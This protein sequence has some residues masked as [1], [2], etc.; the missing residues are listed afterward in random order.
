VASVGG[1]G[2]IT[3]EIANFADPTEVH[4]LGDRLAGRLDRLDV[5]IHNA[6]AL[7]RTRSATAS[8]I[9]ATVAVHLLA[10][11]LL[12]ERLRPL[13]AAS[14]PSRV[15][16]MTSGGMYAQRFDLDDLVMTD[17]DYD[18]TVAY[19]RAKRAQ[20]VL[21]REWQRRYGNEGVDF[22]AVHPGWTDTPGLAAGLPAFSRL[23]H[24]LLRSPSAGADTL[25]WLAA[26][27]AAW[28]AG[29]HL[30][31]D[32]RPRA[33]FYLPWTWKPAAQRVADG[34]ALWDWCKAAVG[35]RDPAG[36]TGRTACG[37]SNSGE[38]GGSIGS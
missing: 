20:T 30:W 37:K 28:P 25:V 12:T 9:E 19:A 21:T 22:H 23:A 38:S 33:E 16:T 2:T 6:G 27:P 7:F 13:L 35:G 15:I 29:G 5:L 4:A 31:L 18:G 14:A 3:T 36:T 1:G 10:P 11:Y 24:P 34:L 32:R 17:Q 8:G 26:A